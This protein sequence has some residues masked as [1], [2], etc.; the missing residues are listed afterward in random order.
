MPTHGKDTDVGKVEELIENHPFD[1]IA[2]GDVHTITRRLR[3]E[4]IQLFAAASGDVNPTHFDADFARTCGRSTVV[5]HSLWAGSL[6]SAVLGNDFPGAGTEYVSQ[7]FRFLRPVMVGDELR[8]TVRVTE[9]HP[10]THHVVFHCDAANQDGHAVVDGVARVVAPR[11]KVV[12][13]QV[14]LPEVTV[15]D[16][17]LRY[18]RLMDL[19]RDLPPA[20]VA[21]AWP[22]DPTSLG[23]AL[24]ALKAGIIDPILCGPEATIRAI[25]ERESLD[26]HGARIHATD[27]RETTAAAACAQLLAQGKA[28]FPMKG[29]LHTDRFLSALLDRGAGLRTGRRVSHVFVMDVP[30]YERTLFITDGAVNPAPDIEA[31]MDIVQ[32]AIDFAHRF[33]VE[34]PRVAIL[35]AIETVNPKMQSTVDAAMLT[36]MA[37]RGQIQ[38]GIVDGPLAFDNAVSLEA[39]RIKGIVSEVAGRADILVAPDLES[40][41]MIAKQLE[42]LADA[43]CAG[44]GL[45]LRVPFV[46]TSRSDSPATRAAS[47]AVT[48]FIVASQDE[49]G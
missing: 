1:D 17:A 30:R 27:G 37:A 4:D 20:P 33:G 45:G 47:C 43:S 7:S 5:A 49:G 28:R 46:L 16:R 9:K 40:G 44:V 42:H 23:G 14:D 39:A 15:T 6:F 2:I 19:A 10:D 13:A 31:K 26:L 34:Y 41:N 22:C 38:G 11:R 32:N 18:Q 8:V 21:V 25:A 12:R 36:L 3:G 24:E 48:R 29:S 35:S